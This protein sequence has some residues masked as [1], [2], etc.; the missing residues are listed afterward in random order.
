MKKTI[1]EWLE[2]LP[3]PYRSEALSNSD[4]EQLIKEIESVSL[5]IRGAFI[6]KDSKEGQGYWEQVYDLMGV[7]AKK[8]NR[9]IAE[10]ICTVTNSIMDSHGLIQDTVNKIET[11]LNKY[12]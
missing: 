7:K 2:T 1:K 5:A 4:S 10:E 6:W 9:E 12:L 11:I 8:S 3:E